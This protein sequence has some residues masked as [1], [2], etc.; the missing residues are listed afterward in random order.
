MSDGIIAKGLY[1]EPCVMYRYILHLYSSLYHNKL[2]NE[3]I[4]YIVV[5]YILPEAMLFY[6]ICC[7]AWLLSS[8]SSTRKRKIWEINSNVYRKKRDTDIN[9]FS[10]SLYV[11]LH[12]HK[13]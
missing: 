12:I 9:P 5:L 7:L 4:E 11:I 3:G 6:Q 10:P 2:Q 8:S 13:S 1:I